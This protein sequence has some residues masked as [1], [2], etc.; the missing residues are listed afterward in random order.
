VTERLIVRPAQEGDRARL[1]S[2][3]QDADFRAFT[4]GPLSEA[5]A[6]R[7]VDRMIELGTRCPFTKQPILERASGVMA[8]YAGADWFDLDGERQV[9]FG[10]RLAPEFRG[11]GYAT[12]ATRTLLQRAALTFTGPVFALIAD[13]N[14]ASH[15]VARKLG[16]DHI[17]QTI[18]DR[19]AGQLYRLMIVRR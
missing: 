17:G 3:F 2:L 8:G 4:P 5:D 13:D 9:E 11:L 6:H 16:F 15:N 10:W 18:V 12:E 14:H 1:V 7:R 19:Y